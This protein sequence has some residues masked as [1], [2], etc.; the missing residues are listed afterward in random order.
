MMKNI[1]GAHNLEVVRSNR[2][3]AINA[4]KAVS[5]SYDCYRLF[6]CG[7]YSCCANAVLTKVSSRAGFPL[8]T[9]CF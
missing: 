1:D 3:P 9:L 4:S 2:A 5:V 8:E 7:R 6:V